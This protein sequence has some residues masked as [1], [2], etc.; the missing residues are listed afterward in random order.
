M[1]LPLRENILN[2]LAYLLKKEAFYHDFQKCP[3][4]AI[5]ITNQILDVLSSFISESKPAAE[6][7]EKEQQKYESISLRLRDLADNFT[8]QIVK[9]KI[10]CADLYDNVLFDRIVCKPVEERVLVPEFYQTIRC[11]TGLVSFSKFA[12]EPAD[13]ERLRSVYAIAV[14]HEILDQIQPYF[15]SYFKQPALHY[16][17]F[18]KKVS[19][20]ILEEQSYATLFENDVMTL[21]NA[22][23]RHNQ[24]YDIAEKVNNFF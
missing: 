16:L 4:K 15:M 7:D 12:S 18:Y 20:Q 17:G 23:E 11:F 5:D 10:L 13:M 9:N 22:I 21:L 24:F 19:V 14:S 6:R 1:K 2:Q 3:S 8:D